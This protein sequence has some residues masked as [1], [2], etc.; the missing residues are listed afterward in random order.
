MTYEKA[1]SNGVAW[2]LDNR[3]AEERPNEFSPV[4]QGRVEDGKDISVASAMIEKGSA[5]SVVADATG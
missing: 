5:K 3:F 2:S 1:P 4:F